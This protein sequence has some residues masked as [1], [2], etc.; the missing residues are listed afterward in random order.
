MIFCCFLADSLHLIQYEDLI[1]LCND[2]RARAAVL[3]SMD[4]IGKD[5]QVNQ[6]QAILPEIIIIR[7]QGLLLLI[8]SVSFTTAVERF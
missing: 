6:S 2:P 3:A 1:Q 5:A 4:A 7:L 8:C